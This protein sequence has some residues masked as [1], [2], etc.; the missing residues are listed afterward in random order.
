LETRTYRFYLHGADSL[1]TAAREIAKYKLH[2]VG[3]QED[4]RDRGGTEQEGTYICIWK[5][6]LG[7]G[8][9]G[10][11]R[12]MSTVKNVESVTNM[13]NMPYTIL[14]FAGVIPLF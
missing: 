14:E 6:D 1:I 13:Y 12:I 5:V 2:L 7:T 9:F 10:H 3:V 4:R 8:Y 11:E